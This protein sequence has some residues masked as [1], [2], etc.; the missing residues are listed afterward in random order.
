MQCRDV[1]LRFS[2]RCV[3]TD[4]AVDCARLMRDHAIG[5]LPVV[6]RGG[7]LIGV[8]TDRDLVIRQLAENRPPNTPV[9]DLMTR[10]GLL[11]CHAEEEL[12]AVEARMAKAE[13]SRA[14]VIDRDGRCVGVVSM[15]DIAQVEKPEEVGRVLHD[16]TKREAARIELPR[17]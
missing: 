10:S 16:V 11:T 12:R 15:S 7:R 17:R 4:T 13:K 5:F 6:D 14:V 1:M 2:Y 3:E 9:N 8:V